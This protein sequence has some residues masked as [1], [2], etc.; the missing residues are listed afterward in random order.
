MLSCEKGLVQMVPGAGGPGFQPCS[1]TCGPQSQAHTMS[2]KGCV[3]SA[4]TCV[5]PPAG[6]RKRKD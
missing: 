5:F 6:R 4:I 2:Q 1:T 3:C